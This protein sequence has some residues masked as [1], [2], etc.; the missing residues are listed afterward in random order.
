MFQRIKC[1]VAIVSIVVVTCATPTWAASSMAGH[2]IVLDCGPSFSG[3]TVEG[4]SGP[5]WA[6]PISTE[7][8]P[9]LRDLTPLRPIGHT[10]GHER[11]THPTLRPNA[12]GGW[13]D[14]SFTV[15]FWSIVG[16]IVIVGIIAASMND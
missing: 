13:K 7:A 11:A 12:A 16:P 14:A 5:T 4:P 3:P 2:G 10:A 8:G 1:G 15:K 6:P 9:R